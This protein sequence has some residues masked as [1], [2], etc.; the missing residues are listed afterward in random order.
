M[1]E[2]ELIDADTYQKQIPGQMREHILISVLDHFAEISSDFSLTKTKALPHHVTNG[3]GENATAAADICSPAVLG[4]SQPDGVGPWAH[5]ET[6]TR[7]PGSV[8]VAFMYNLQASI[9][10]LWVHHC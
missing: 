1:I 6:C 9:M 8:S 4:L 10:N 7:G 3:P 5:L 2:S